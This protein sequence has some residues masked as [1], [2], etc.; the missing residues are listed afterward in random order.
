M[1]IDRSGR[2]WRL[3][4]TQY[5]EGWQWDARHDDHGRSS[6]L[7][8]TKTIAE[9]DARRSI[10]SFDAVAASGEYLHRLQERRTE[11]RLTVE[12]NEAITR[13]GSEGK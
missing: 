1:I 5:R 13:A 12:D 6:G 9:E 4:F 7:F 11:C 8:A 3:R 2:K 10:Q